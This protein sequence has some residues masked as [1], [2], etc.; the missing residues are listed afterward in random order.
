LDRTHIIRILRSLEMIKEE[1]LI[2]GNF[3]SGN[4]SRKRSNNVSNYID[5]LKSLLLICRIW[6]C[7]GATRAAYKFL[8]KGGAL[9]HSF[10]ITL[11]ENQCVKP[12]EFENRVPYTL[13]KFDFICNSCCKK[14]VLK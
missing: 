13:T 10:N 3:R 4:I 11:L 6:Q 5:K 2:V 9:H 7:W 8:Q 12:R 1:L 14:R